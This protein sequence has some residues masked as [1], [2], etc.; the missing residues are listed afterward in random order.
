MRLDSWPE[1]VHHQHLQDEP[2]DVRPYRVWVLLGQVETQE[3]E[4]GKLARR[5]SPI[6]CRV[7]RLALTSLP[8]VGLAG[9]CL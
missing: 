7:F 5:R 4:I 2:A 9:L 3:P 8:S 1:T 6:S